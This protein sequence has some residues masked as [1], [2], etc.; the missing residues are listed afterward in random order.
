MQNS[1]PDRSTS[2]RTVLA[3]EAPTIFVSRALTYDVMVDGRITTS[4]Q[5][6]ERSLVTA[7]AE[8]S[9]VS[10]INV[11]RPRSAQVHVDPPG[12]RFSNAGYLTLASTISAI[13]KGRRAILITTGYDPRLM[14]V[15]ALF[16]LR[17]FRSYSFIYDTHKA[18]IRH[19]RL[20]RRIAV[21]LYFQLGFVLAGW[22][23]GWIVLNDGFIRKTNRRIAYLRT[24]IGMDSRNRDVRQ[25]QRRSDGTVFLVS[26]TLN[27][28]NGTRLLIEAMRELRGASIELQVFGYGPLADQVATAAREDERIVFH[29]QVD[30]AVVIERQCEADYLIHLRDPSAVAGDYSF[31]SKLA[32]YLSSETPV[33]SNRF[34]GIDDF[35]KFVTEIEA[36]DAK[37]VARAIAGILAGTMQVPDNHVDRLHFVRSRGWDR[38]AAQ[39]KA[40]VTGRPS[41]SQQTGR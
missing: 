27:D 22:L 20:P 31:P 40:F 15:L 16:R 29:G 38:V 36:Y 41:A 3:E 12:L 24:W 37:S 11:G 21:D 32:E 33:L 19:K 7:Y 25:R 9:D 14:L 1:M 26:G 35:A 8:I 17:G 30:N 18:A 10:V 2:L 6:F 28:E 39:V 23:N 5:K 13:A 34:P 4:S